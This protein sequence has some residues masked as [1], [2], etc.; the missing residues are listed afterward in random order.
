MAV[1]FSD[2]QLAFEFVS[3]GGMGENEAYLDRR[4]GKIYWHSEFGDNNEELPD[5]IDHEKYIA[6][7]DK[8]ELDLGKPLVLDFAREFLPDDY[9][10]VHHIFSGRGAYRRYKDLLVRR[11]ALERWYD[12]SNKAEEAALLEWCVENKIDLSGT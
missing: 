7:P 9:D 12:F 8:R 10:E 6:I 2:L 1:S 5:D 4:S 11:G 3:S